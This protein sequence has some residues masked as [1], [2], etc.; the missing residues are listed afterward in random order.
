MCECVGLF[1]FF[2][3]SFLYSGDIPLPPYTLS[4]IRNVLY[5]D[6]PCVVWTL[7]NV[8]MIQHVID[9]IRKKPI[10]CYGVL[11]CDKQVPCPAGLQ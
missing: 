8:Y 3:V 11:P 6:Y 5:F 10:P 1:L 9:K 2:G 7:Y 4:L